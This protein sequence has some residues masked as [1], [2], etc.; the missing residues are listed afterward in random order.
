VNTNSSGTRKICLGYH[1]NVHICITLF[2]RFRS[3][4]VNTQVKSFWWDCFTSYQ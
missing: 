1:T 4:T 2:W 3:Y